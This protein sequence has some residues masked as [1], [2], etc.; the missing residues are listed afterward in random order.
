MKQFEAKNRIESY[1]TDSLLSLNNDFIYDSTSNL[2]K[3]KCERCTGYFLLDR[4]VLNN[5]LI[6][7]NKQDT[8]TNGMQQFILSLECDSCSIMNDIFII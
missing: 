8:D 3:H 1:S 2:Y 6:D 4:N 7:I 5:L